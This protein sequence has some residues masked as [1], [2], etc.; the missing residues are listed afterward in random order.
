MQK[1]DGQL[2]HVPDD[3]QSFEAPD[4]VGL[5]RQHQYSNFGNTGT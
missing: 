4:C 3:V 5:L 2:R 1:V